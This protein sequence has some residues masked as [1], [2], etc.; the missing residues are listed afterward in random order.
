MYDEDY[1][2]HHGILGMK[3]GIRRYQNE[4]GTRT[5]LGKKHEYELEGNA[6]DRY[7][8]ANKAAAQ[9]RFQRDD[10]IDSDINS[11][12]ENNYNNHAKGAI[13]K[14]EFKKNANAIMKEGGERYKESKKQYKQD[15][16]DNKTTEAEGY[17]QDRNAKLKRGAA[18][19]AGILV[20]AAAGYALYKTGAGEKV[21]NH[22][23]EALAGLFTKKAGE[24]LSSIANTKTADLSIDM[25]G[26]KK[27]TSSAVT[28]AISK[29]S[30]TSKP[31]T[32]LNAGESFSI[33][34]PG[35]K[36]SASS[37]SL[38]VKSIPKTSSLAVKP[39]PKANSSSGTNA[40][41]SGASVSVPIKRRASAPTASTT[42]VS[43]ARKN[44][45]QAAIKVVNDA[46]DRTKN[47]N[48]G[49]SSFNND[50]ISFTN[51][52]IGSSGR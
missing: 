42:S 33:S 11:Q 49:Y 18:I 15:L 9:R 4:D 36:T 34:T 22:G 24:N 1:L 38:A 27:S 8:S 30:A 52:L 7:N 5:T 2:A 45:P 20:T 31:S 13:S 23:K 21:L 25:K 37:T 46:V 39:T 16:K 48:A 10:M 6:R 26:G 40:T 17:R 41:E 29:P 47:I 28:S 14:R 43:A 32:N 19:A 50:I 35:Q 44:T 12:L 51:S 3:W